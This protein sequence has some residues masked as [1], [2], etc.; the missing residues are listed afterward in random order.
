MPGHIT[1]NGGWG[2]GLDGYGASRWT[3][4]RWV[5][6]LLRKL[7]SDSTTWHREGARSTIMVPRQRRVAILQMGPCLP[8]GMA[9]PDVISSCHDIF[10]SW[11]NKTMNNN[12]ILLP[13]PKTYK[14]T[15]S[16]EHAHAPQFPL[17]RVQHNACRPECTTHISTTEIGASK[18]WKYF[19]KQL[20][21]Y[22]SQGE[23][24]IG[25]K[26]QLW[27]SGQKA[28]VSD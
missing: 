11:Q 5:S 12:I 9:E 23:Y 8:L 24:T 19:P 2:K 15:A 21:V 27:T 18:S 1:Y 26:G 10:I 6:S 16:K 28:R 25:I 20:K 14:T 4:N 22:T 3:L 13:I 7:V 17:S